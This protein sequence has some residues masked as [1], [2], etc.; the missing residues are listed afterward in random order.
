M[1]RA[2]HCSQRIDVASASTIVLERV[3]GN[4][5]MPRR[6]VVLIETR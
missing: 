4:Y 5:V 2:Q 6:I 1:G 3:E